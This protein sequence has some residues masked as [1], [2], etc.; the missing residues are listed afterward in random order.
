M[1]VPQ[2]E[3]AP[4]AQKSAPRTSRK[5]YQP[6]VGKINEILKQAT[7]NDLNQIKGKWGE[8]RASL[9][10]SHAALLN[11]AEPVAASADAVIIKFKHEMICQMAM[12]RS[13][14]LEAVSAALN[15]LTG[16]RFLFLGVPEEH[17]L[18]IRE[19]FLSTQHETGESSGEGQTEEEPHITEAIKIFGTEFVEIID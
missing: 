9:I 14:F 5:G 4:Q 15:K 2:Q 13:D 6:A 16:K 19:S 12:D 8:M 17:W 1:A 11:D 18:P 3:A 7:K 10:K